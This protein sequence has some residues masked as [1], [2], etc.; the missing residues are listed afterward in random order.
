M[1]AY[2][3]RVD[4]TLKTRKRIYY[5]GM[6][7]PDSYGRAVDEETF[8]GAA[9]N[10]MVSVV[11]AMRQVGHRAMI[12]SLPFIGAHAKRSF[13]RAV[14]T[15]DDGV[16]AVFVATL[17]S[18]YLRKLFGPVF[19]A[20]FFWQRARSGDAVILYN[21]AIE[22]LLTILLLRFKGVH[23]VQ[24]IEDVPR[25][26]GWDVREMLHQL[27]FAL[28]FRLTSPRKMVVAEHV[29]RR[30][31]LSDYVV[32]RGVAAFN[33]SQDLSE[34]GKWA[35]L[36]D[37]K[38]LI[39]HFGGTLRS[40]TGVELFCASVAALAQSESRLVRP[41]VFV[42]TGEGALDQFRALQDSLTSSSKVK[43]EIK[44][45]LRKADYD[46]LID[47]C[48]VGLS[49]RQ[50]GS[51]YSGTT[52]PSK[53]IEI[54]SRGLA[55][56]SSDRG[57]VTALFGEESAFLLRDYNAGELSSVII[58]LA[59]DPVHAEQVAVAGRQLSIQTF[60]LEMVGQQMARLI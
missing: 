21:H 31:G 28:T 27:G 35:A 12:V 5:V 20:A 53:V 15:S 46:V 52:F 13:Y 39:L 17:R 60:S 26:E 9:E 54:T 37:G 41:V 55:L 48:H 29:A 16:P 51:D 32:I 11:K 49:L 44:G 47:S 25:H 6:I 10:K 8:A 30:L 18:K 7:T 56:I 36:Q 33:H 34:T 45:K 58:R 59:Q 4:G 22:Y 50:P 19:L 24:D 40:D 14:V 2:M 42:V 57:D 1:L 38:P 43:V 3:G 23:V